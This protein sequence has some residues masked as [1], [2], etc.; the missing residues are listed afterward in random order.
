MLR[1]AFSSIRFDARLLSDIQRGDAQFLLV[2]MWDRWN[3]LFSDELS[4]V[5]RSLISALRDFRNRWAHQDHLTEQD[6]YRVLDDIERLLH[7]INS[8]MAPRASELRHDPSIVCGR[9]KLDMTDETEHFESRRPTC[10]ACPVRRRSALPFSVFCDAMEWNLISVGSAWH[11]S[12]GVAPVSENLHQFS[13]P[14]RM[15]SLR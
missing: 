15:W 3:D 2:L 14:E 1:D 5:E 6:A 10:C 7:A 12:P 11:D 13:W 8:D 9:Q 4:F